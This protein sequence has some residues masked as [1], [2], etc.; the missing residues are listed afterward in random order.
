MIPD[1]QDTFWYEG[2][3]FRNGLPRNDLLVNYDKLI[4]EKV[5]S[6]FNIDSSKKIIMY[7]PTFRQEYDLEMNN[8]LLS[9]IIQVYS[10]TFN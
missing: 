2:E 1:V 8:E 10:K 5:Y 9:K 6:Y 4:I 3:T 7:A